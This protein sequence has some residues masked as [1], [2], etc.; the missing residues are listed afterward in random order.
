MA[1][2]GDSTQTEA[3]PSDASTSG[4][5][6]AASADADGAD[7]ASGDA[8]GTEDAVAGVER[9]SSPERHVAQEP[10]PVTLLFLTGLRR[11]S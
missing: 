2:D 7:A 10:D 5:A 4:D 6:G 8:D 1:A 11:F 9:P 3:S